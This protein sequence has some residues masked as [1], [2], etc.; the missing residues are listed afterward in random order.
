MLE[1]ETMES[2]AP[3]NP[4]LSDA[5]RMGTTIGTNVTVMFMNHST[6]LQTNIVIVNT[7]TGERIKVKF[8]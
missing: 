6:D 8:V 4:F 3:G 7:D 5:V 2:I 1:I